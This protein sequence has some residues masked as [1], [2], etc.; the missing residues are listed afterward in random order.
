MKR[1]SG[2]RKKASDLSESVHQQINMYAIA[3]A[4]AGE[5]VL[6]LAQPSEAKIVYTPAHKQL[7]INSPFYLDLNHDRINDFK[8]FLGWFT[9]SGNRLSS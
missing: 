3:A 2:P 7:P 9:H 5:G 4:A 8:F 6:A 1:S